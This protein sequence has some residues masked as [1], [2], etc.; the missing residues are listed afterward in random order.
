MACQLLFWN[1]SKEE[2]VTI[3]LYGPMKCHIGLFAIVVGVCVFCLGKFRE[4]LV[5]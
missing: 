3:I 4:G 5:E 1:L 2:T